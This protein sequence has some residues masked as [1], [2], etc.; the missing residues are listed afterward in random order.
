MQ[1]F[2][3][4]FILFFTI[5]NGLCFAISADLGDVAV[6]ARPLSIGKA[7][8]GYAEDA[9]SIFLN[10]AGLA[11]ISEF[12]LVSMT[13]KMLDE[14]TYVS[15]GATT[16]SLIGN[17]G[18]G[19]INA[20][21]V[22]I[23]LTTLSSATSEIDINQYG[24]TDYASS[25]LYLSLANSLFR[26]FLIGGSLKI[27][28]QGF[29]QTTGSLEGAT[30]IGTDADVGIKWKIKKGISLGAIFQNV[31]PIRYSGR[32]VW[33]KGYTESIPCTLKIGSAFKILGDDGLYNFKQQKLL[34]N[35]DSEMSYLPR[36]GLWHIGFE[37]FL[38]PMLA[39]RIGIDQKPRAT[40]T[41]VGIDNNLTAGVGVKYRGFS[42]DYAYHQYGEISENIA[43]YFSIGFIN[44]K[45]TSRIKEILEQP[46]F[47]TQFKKAKNLKTFIDV[48]YDYWAK[49]PIEY[50]ATLGM[51]GGYP[52]DTFRPDQA[53]TRAELAVLLVKAKRFQVSTVEVDLFDD[54]PKGFWAAPHIGVALKRKYISGYSDQKFRPWKEITRAEAIIVLSKFAGLLEPSSINY[55]PYPDISYKHW[56]ARYIAVAKQ[57]GLL[58]YLS[59]GNFEPDKSFTRAEA[60]EVI[61]KMDFAKEEIRDFLKK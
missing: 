32:F 56:A 47:T 51:I 5:L 29:S 19:Y 18:F 34:L 9:S 36:P 60:A 21:T 11:Q 24:S 26:D 27:F 8:V 20:S 2:F 15:I 12:G 57:A 44:E 37:W 30:G 38:N 41:G 4:F 40:D 59:G 42:F 1:R 61:S 28:Y 35:V 22:G 53:L 31:L 54:V 33:A 52:D 49:E 55:N 3:L 50:L 6:G 46:T 39:L 45:T 10:P 16:P 23:P 14:V 58:E 48:S 43:H 25:I 17:L 13:G 7:Y